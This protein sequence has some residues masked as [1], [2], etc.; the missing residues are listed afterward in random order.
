M[1]GKRQAFN[2]KKIFGAKPD[3][4]SYGV[5]VKKASPD[6][7]HLMVFDPGDEVSMMR[8]LF[9]FRLIDAKG[10]VAEAFEGLYS[11]MQGAWW[12]GDS[13]VAAVPVSDDI[14]CLLLLH[15]PKRRYSVVPFNSYQMRARVTSRG[16]WVCV[17]LQEFRAWFG[18]E[19]RPPDDTYLPFASLRWFPVQEKWDLNAAIRSAPRIRWTPPPSRELKA[20]ARKN[21]ITLG[22]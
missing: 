3:P 8:Y 2:W 14:D 5:Y 11:P 21:G 1:T 10:T 17:D 4:R 13:R 18:R 16:V 19:F 12:S 9:Q 20:Y 22:L 6:R 7:K 15:L